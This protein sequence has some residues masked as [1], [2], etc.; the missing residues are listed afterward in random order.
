MGGFGGYGC[1]GFGFPYS[2]FGYGFGN[3]PYGGFWFGSRPNLPAVTGHY[4]NYRSGAAVV[5][6]APT[7]DITSV[8]EKPVTAPLVQPLHPSSEAV[9]GLSPTVEKTSLHSTIPALFRV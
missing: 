8:A 2:G 6:K 7:L 1:G 9:T 4:N 5:K 3:V